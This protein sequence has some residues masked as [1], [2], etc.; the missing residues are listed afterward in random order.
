MSRF[1][2][3]ADTPAQPTIEGDDSFKGINEKIAREMLPPG[4]IHRGRNTRMRNGDCRVRPGTAMPG[5]ANAIV[6]DEILGSGFYSNPNGPESILI[7][8]PD[9]VY[10]IADGTY[11]MPIAIPAKVGTLDTPCEFVQAFDK[12]LMFRGTERTPLEWDGL[13]ATGFTLI[14]APTNTEKEQ[15]PNAESASVFKSRLLVPSNRDDVAV[16]DILDYTQFDP[17]LENWRINLGS[18]DKLVRIFPWAQ[19]GAIMFKDRTILLMANF[20]DPQHPELAQLQMV[21]DE[22]GLCGRWAAVRVGGDIHFM[23]RTHPGIYQ[24]TQVLQESVQSSP[25]PISDAISPTINRINWEAADKIR[26]VNNGEQ[27]VWF[28]PLDGATVNNAALVWNAATQEW[29]SSPDVWSPDAGI[30]RTIER[31]NLQ[32]DQAYVMNYQGHASIYAIDAGTRTVYVLYARGA[33]TDQ[34]VQGEQEID[35]L[36]EPRGYATLGWNAASRRDNQRMEIGLETWRPNI[37]ITELTESQGDERE[38]VAGLTKDR[39]HNTRFATPDYDP[40]NANDD[41]FNPGREDYSVVLPAEG[42]LLGQNGIAL[43]LKQRWIQ[44]FALRARAHWFSYRVRNTQGYCAVTGIL[45]ESTG[46]QRQKR[47]A[48]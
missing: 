43:G 11:P 5:F 32:I 4:Y 26:A 16:S 17:Q 31:W 6:F 20:E 46:T 27:V 25:V 13:S 35:Y 21:N 41:F 34:L 23:S 10:A 28:V 9:M 1:S 40:T 7:A 45:Q 44:P 14:K 24:L 48:A 38:L 29:E 8:A 30:G 47:I 39:T 33:L 36:M 3:P 18:A 42:I 37:D 2:K 19:N 12:V 15:I 22:L